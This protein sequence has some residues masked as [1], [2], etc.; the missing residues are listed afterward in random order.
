V[1]SADALRT[2]RSLT[3]FALSFDAAGTALLAWPGPAWAG[4]P[5]LALLAAGL[6]AAAAGG[7]RLS[8]RLAAALEPRYRARVRLWVGAGYAGLVL[9]TLAVAVGAPTPHLLSRA[10]PS[11]SPS[12]SEPS[13][14]SWTCWEDAWP[15]SRTR[16]S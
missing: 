14:S 15:R 12:S 3:L 16:S 10:S 7:D 5:A 1:R 13:C 6:A 2:A 4:M 8:S 11:C 9:L